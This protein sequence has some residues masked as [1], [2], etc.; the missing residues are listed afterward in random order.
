MLKSRHDAMQTCDPELKDEDYRMLLALINDKR[1]SCIP[2]YWKFLDLSNGLQE[3]NDTSSYRF[4]SDITLNFTDYG[5]NGGIGKLRK[6]FDP[7]CEEMMIVSSATK[8]EGRELRYLE[9]D[10]IE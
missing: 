6:L 10:Y 1:V 8:E 2:K 4:I 7:P 3:C 5:K 9:D